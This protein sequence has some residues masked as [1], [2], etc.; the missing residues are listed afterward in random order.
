MT[1]LKNILLNGNVEIIFLNDME[2]PI[3]IYEF[4]IEEFEKILK[5]MD[6]QE[7]A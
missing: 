7:I 6:R 4:D 3:S 5:Q 2:V 1:I